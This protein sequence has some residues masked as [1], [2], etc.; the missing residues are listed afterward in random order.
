MTTSDS[1]DKLSTRPDASSKVVEKSKVYDEIYAA[2]DRFMD[3]VGPADVLSV[4]TSL[5]VS[6]VVGY[7]KHAGHDPDKSITINGGDMRDITIH[8]VKDNGT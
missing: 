8:A 3:Q 4:A 6:V 7:T 5:F 2:F 1:P